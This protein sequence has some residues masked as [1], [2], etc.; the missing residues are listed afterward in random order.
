MKEFFTGVLVTAPITAFIVQLALS[1]KQEVTTAQER[2]Y[3]DQQ[4]A[5]QVFDHQFEQA[6]NTSKLPAHNENRAERITKLEQRKN[7]F[8]E[9]FDKQF[10]SSKQDVDELRSAISE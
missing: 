10:A 1:G 7:Q 9:E 4:L 8:D 3:V 6:W 2:H 5:T